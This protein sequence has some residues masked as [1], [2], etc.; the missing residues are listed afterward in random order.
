MSQPAEPSEIST[1]FEAFV[2]MGPSRSLHRLWKNWDKLVKTGRPRPTYQS[3]CKWAEKYNW[4]E[5]AAEKDRKILQKLSEKSDML[6]VNYT[7]QILD[8]L[9]A[10]VQ[11]C[12][13]EK[14]NPLP[15][16]NYQDLNDTLRLMLQILGWSKHPSAVGRSPENQTNIKIIKVIDN[17]QNPNSASTETSIVDAEVHEVSSEKP[18]SPKARKKEASQSARRPRAESPP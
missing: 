13:D 7:A 16:Q 18:S 15:I 8:F 17:P 6:R 4:K 12:F 2:A 11:T 5:R 9:W 3:I 1:V 14:G 10:R